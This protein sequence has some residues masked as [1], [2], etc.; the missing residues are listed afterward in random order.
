MRITQWM[1]ATALVK[2]WAIFNAVGALGVVIQLALVGALVH[3][4]RLHYLV[5]TIVAVEA[6]ILHNFAWHQRWTWRDRPPGSGR[7]RWLT[8]LLTFNLLNG[9]IS[10]TGNAAV[11]ALLSGAAGVEPVTANAVAILLCSVANFAA[12]ETLV[13][14][15]VAV[16]TRSAS[17]A[18]NAEC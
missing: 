10:L 7:G 14:R 15:P 1:T 11:M 5:A 9:G 13:F 6:A 4:A 3:G 16:A 17:G 12:S 2:R 18:V 8:R